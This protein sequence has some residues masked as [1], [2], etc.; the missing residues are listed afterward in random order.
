MAEIEL[1]HGEIVVV[2][3]ADVPLV[4]RFK[5]RAIYEGRCVYAFRGCRLPSGQKTTQRM[6]TLITGRSMVD[7]INGNGLDN[8]RS[9]LRPAT[10]QMNQGNR[11][12]AKLATSSPFKGVCWNKTARQWQAAI[13]MFGRRKYLGIFTDPADAA[14][15][16]DAAARDF[17]GEFAALNFPV[18]GERSALTGLIIGDER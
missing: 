15:V 9:N 4:Q 1:L 16:Y 14:R 12:K 5:W 10:N 17:F 8:R 2:D 7:H 13:G 18:R 6:H 3:E 11:R